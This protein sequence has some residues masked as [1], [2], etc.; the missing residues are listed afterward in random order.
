[1][2]ESISTETGLRIVKRVRANVTLSNK[3][4]SK[5]VNTTVLPLD[6]AR[7]VSISKGRKADIFKNTVFD[8]PARG[9]HAYETED[10]D[11]VTV[12]GNKVTTFQCAKRDGTWEAELLGQCYAVFKDNHCLYE[13]SQ[14]SCEKKRIHG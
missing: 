12:S 10:G 9:F 11:E 7:A 1:M 5:H 8:W 2:V 14:R 13:Q 6:K 4:K 3:C